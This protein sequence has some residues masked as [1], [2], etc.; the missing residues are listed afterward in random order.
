MRRIAYISIVIV[1]PSLVTFFSWLLTD[2]CPDMA[3]ELNEGAAVSS[4]MNCYETSDLYM[5]YIFFT[6]ATITI[7]FVAYAAAIL[8]RKF[9]TK[10]QK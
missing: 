9:L 10:D 3:V 6:I 8:W 7:L 2:P 4:T 5:T 1:V